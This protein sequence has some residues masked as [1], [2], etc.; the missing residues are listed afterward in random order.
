MYVEFA[1]ASFGDLGVREAPRHVGADLGHHFATVRFL[2]TSS[3]I[4]AGERPRSRAMDLAL[5]FLS[6]ARSIEARSALSN[7]K[8]CRCFLSATIPTFPL[9]RAPFGPALDQ[10]FS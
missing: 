8:Y 1:R 4:E 5:R 3:V 9:R 6:S 10:G 7:L 2:F